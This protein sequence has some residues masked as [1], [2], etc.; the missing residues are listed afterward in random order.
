MLDRGYSISRSLNTKNIITNAEDVRVDDKI[1]IILHMAK[2]L[3]GQSAR[4]SI[5][6]D[7][8]EISFGR[9]DKAPVITQH[10]L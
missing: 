6:A 5:T 2:R 9:F 10:F 3:L 1:E 8:S 7:I 4:L